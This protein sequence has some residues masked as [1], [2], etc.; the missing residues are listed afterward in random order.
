MPMIAAPKQN[1]FGNPWLGVIIPLSPFQSKQSDKKLPPLILIEMTRFSESKQGQNLEKSSIY[2]WTGKDQGAG[3]N[4]AAI[5]MKQLT[6]R[7]LKNTLHFVLKCQNFHA[8]KLRFVQ[9]TMW[10]RKPTV[11]SQ[12]QMENIMTVTVKKTF[13]FE[14]RFLPWNR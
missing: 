11:E 4:P 12:P 9:M 14:V 7:T 6:W 3:Q 8:F 5:P 1:Q 10:H 13:K 2:C